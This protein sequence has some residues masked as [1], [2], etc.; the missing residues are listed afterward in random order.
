MFPCAYIYMGMYTLYTFL[1]MMS[2]HVVI[3]RTSEPIVGRA[4]PHFMTSWTCILLAR[5]PPLPTPRPCMSPNCTAC[6]TYLRVGPAC[7]N[8]MAGYDLLL[9][10]PTIRNR[11]WKFSG[12]CEFGFEPGTSLRLKACWKLKFHYDHNSFKQYLGYKHSFVFLIS[13]FGGGGI[14]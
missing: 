10:T 4:C 8:S 3:P 2:K 14:L 7:C 12:V 11:L 13:F 1:W 5:P 9:L 6:R